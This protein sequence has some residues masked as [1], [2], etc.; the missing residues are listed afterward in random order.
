MVGLSR[1]R[2]EMVSL[3][4]S[5]SIV[6]ET[7][8]QLLLVANGSFLGNTAMSVH[9][10]NI[11]IKTYQSNLVYTMRSWNNLHR[12][13]KKPNNIKIFERNKTEGYKHDN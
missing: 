2:K 9:C 3:I 7:S 12:K 5:N 6:L 4:R 13:I 10:L 11:K 1:G 8:H